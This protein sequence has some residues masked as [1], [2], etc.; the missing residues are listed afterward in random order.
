MR[1]DAT[2]RNKPGREEA[3]FT[4]VEPRLMQPRSR[5]FPIARGQHRHSVS[6]P[7]AASRPRNEG[8]PT[9]IDSLSEPARSLI[10]DILA[11]LQPR[12]VTD[13]ADLHSLLSTIVVR[14]IDR[15]G[16]SLP[17]HHTPSK[18]ARTTA[19]L[20]SSSDH[21]AHTPP[22]TDTVLRVGSLELDLLDRTAKRGDRRIDLRPR[23]FQLLKYLMQRCDTLLTRA[24]L[25]TEVWSYKFVPETNLV[26]VYMSKLRRKVD[27]PNE[28]ALIRNVRGAGFVLSAMP[29]PQHSAPGTAEGATI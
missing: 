24:T 27:G 19:G 23:E 2:I 15:L 26:D 5:H 20:A 4:G 28:T 25:L 13:E 22:S 1:I 17:Q 29:F 21:S 10:A 14:L 9:D 7:R 18:Q 3:T 6:P 8:T 12:F 11:D 16:V